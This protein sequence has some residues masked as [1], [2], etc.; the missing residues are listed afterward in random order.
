MIRTPD[1]WA[2]LFAGLAALQLVTWWVFWSWHR[3]V[4]ERSKQNTDELMMLVCEH[5]DQERARLL[6][7]VDEVCSLR[8]TRLRDGSG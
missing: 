8:G 7:L 1:F 4:F 3:S 5:R 2:A 6:Q